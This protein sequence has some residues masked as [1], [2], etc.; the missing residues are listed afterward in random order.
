MPVKIYGARCTEEHKTIV[1]ERG[2]TLRPL[3]EFR[4]VEIERRR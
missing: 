4:Y 2:W 1:I 3:S